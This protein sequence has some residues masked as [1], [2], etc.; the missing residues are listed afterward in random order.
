MIARDAPIRCAHRQA[1]DR[2]PSIGCSMIIPRS[3]KAPLTS[4]QTSAVALHEAYDDRR[5]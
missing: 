3:P 2:A 5:R 1:A 4:G